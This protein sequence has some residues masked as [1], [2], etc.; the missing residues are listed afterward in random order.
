VAVHRSSET[1]CNETV[2]V[3]GSAA[4]SLHVTS[5][6]RSDVINRYPSRECSLYVAAERGQRLSF[7]VFTLGGPSDA[8]E[9][10]GGSEAAAWVGVGAGA[11][12]GGS[13]RRRPCDA[14]RT[15]YIVDGGGRTVSSSLCHLPRFQS[16]PKVVYTSTGWRVA[17]Y[18]TWTGGHLHSVQPD[19]SLDNGNHSFT[20]YILK[21]EGK[22]FAMIHSPVKRPWI[23]YIKPT[24]QSVAS[25]SG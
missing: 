24:L 12:G 13:A 6:F 5:S 3:N 7:A 2:K 14:D 16:R 10:G 25:E 9:V 1:A 11:H 22:N 15:L 4:I 18:W 8:A 23:C 21:V 19:T 20:S 17:V